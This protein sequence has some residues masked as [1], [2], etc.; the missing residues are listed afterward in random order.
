VLL[1][2]VSKV[3]GFRPLTSG[4]YVLG[5]YLVVAPSTGPDVPAVPVW[6]DT[7]TGN[8]DPFITRVGLAPQLN[9]ASWRA[10]RFSFAEINNP[11]QGPAGADSDGDRVVNLLEYAFALDPRMIDRPL[12]HSTFSG[13]GP[14]T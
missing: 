7:R 14:S 1:G 11:N 10:A 12:F 5:D 3:V 9:F 2:A 8:P 13:T 6:V 4:V